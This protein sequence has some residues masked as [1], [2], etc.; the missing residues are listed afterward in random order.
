MT[1]AELRSIKKRVMAHYE[2]YSNTNLSGMIIDC[3]VYLDQLRIIRLARRKT[4]KTGDEQ[5]RFIVY[6]EPISSTA[7]REDVTADLERIWL[8]DLR[9]T[10]EAHTITQA[11][12]EVCLARRFRLLGAFDA[13]SQPRLHAARVGGGDQIWLGHTC[14]FFAP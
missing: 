12:E 7:T 11:N 1:A 8:S 10:E 9:L 5:C 4:K 2:R 14:P 3:Q 13:A 6:C